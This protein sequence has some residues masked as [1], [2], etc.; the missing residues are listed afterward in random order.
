M[1]YN[2]K[3]IGLIAADTTRSR[4][5]IQ[6]LARH[7]LLPKRIILMKAVG[8]D[9]PGQSL[10]TLPRDPDH[11]DID[12]IWA[13]G[14]FDPNQQLDDSIKGHDVSITRLEA[15]DINS[16]QVIKAVEQF[17]GHTLIYSGYGGQILRKPLLAAGAQ[18]LHIHGGRVPSFKGSTANYYSLIDEGKI[19]ASAI[20]LTSD[21]DGGPLLARRDFDAPPDRTKLDHLHDSAARAILLCDVIGAYAR[22]GTWPHVTIDKNE[23]DETF[24]VIHP[25]LKHIAVLGSKRQ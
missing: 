22:D 7:G 6:N 9:L 8:A 23:L 19:S 13:E 15:D 3:G 21:L 5:Y 1:Q 20:F 12:A 17:D 4:A 2:L 25:V 16:P 18:F 14:H 10:A 11:A 24:F